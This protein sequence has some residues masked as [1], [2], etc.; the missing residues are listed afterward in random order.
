[1]KMG[2]RTAAIFSASL[3]LAGWGLPKPAMAGV[4]KIPAAETIM[5]ARAK[6]AKKPGGRLAPPPKKMEKEPAGARGSGAPDYSKEEEMPKRAGGI[7]GQVP[8]K[9]RFLDSIEA[10]FTHAGYGRVGSVNMGSVEAGHG[11]VSAGVGMGVEKLDYYRENLFFATPKLEVRGLLGDFELYLAGS[12]PIIP[13]GPADSGGKR[14]ISASAYGTLGGVWEALPRGRG[15]GPSFRLGAEVEASGGWGE[16]E[17]QQG[18]VQAAYGAAVAYGKITV[19]AIENSAF[20]GGQAHGQ[21]G[22]EIFAPHHHKLRAGI[23]ISQQDAD[24]AAEFFHTPFEKGGNFSVTFKGGNVVPGLY[25]WGSKGWGM[26]GDAGGAGVGATLAFGKRGYKGR[27][28][29]ERGF[30]SGMGSGETTLRKDTSWG[31]RGAKEFFLGAMEES[32]GLS[33]FGKKYRGM[34]EAY[35]VNAARELGRLGYKYG[36]PELNVRSYF[37]KEA[38][39]VAAIGEESAFRAVRRAALGKKNPGKTGICSNVAALQ[40]EFLRQA[41]WKAYTI[42]VAGRMGQDIL[43]NAEAG[44][45]N[46][47]EP[48]MMTIAKSPGKKGAFLFNYWKAYESKDGRIW[49]IVREIS[50]EA[51]VIPLGMYIYGKGNKLIGHYESKE[52]ALN[53][54]MAGDRETLK[55]A[56]LHSRP[57]KNGK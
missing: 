37:S 3:A 25:G 54:A 17:I 6:E 10:E 9:T 24:F 23:V 8:K 53:R 22:A 56:L 50:K 14:G 40:S 4:N 2:W 32:Q 43:G 42:Q 57:R 15:K 34:D 7:L 29:A 47:V 55:E 35:I 31:G 13:K 12:A 11:P 46:V 19:Y 51:G 44:T 26:I 41:G 18:I 27:A 20:F 52:K 33:E 1:M 49:P 45:P 48:H 39:E 28:R 21:Y 36:N 30:G 16:D 5:G 38:K